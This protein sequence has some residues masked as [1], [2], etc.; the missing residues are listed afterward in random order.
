MV[1]FRVSYPITIGKGENSYQIR[2]FEFD[3]TNRLG[4]IYEEVVYLMEDQIKYPDSL[5]IIC[6]REVSENNDLYVTTV[7]YNVDTVI[8]TVRDEKVKIDN[9][10]LV[11][12]YVIELEEYEL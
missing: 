4:V 11:F 7:N 3:I 9:Q 2:N 5:C 10:D 8:F 1:N 12:S 6:A